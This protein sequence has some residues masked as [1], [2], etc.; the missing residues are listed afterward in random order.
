MTDSGGTKRKKK[1]LIIIAIITWAI[2]IFLFVYSFIFPLTY[3]YPDIDENS[4]HK[5]IDDDF[6]QVI[7]DFDMQVLRIILSGILFVSGLVIFIFAI[8]IDKKEYMVDNDG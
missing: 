8:L 4:T 1:I 6:N 7:D 5:E 3:N 2:S